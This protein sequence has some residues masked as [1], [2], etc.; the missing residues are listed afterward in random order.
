MVCDLG[1]CLAITEGKGIAKGHVNQT[2]SF[3]TQG[4]S[5]GR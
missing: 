1:A 3:N 5:N 4:L 2:V